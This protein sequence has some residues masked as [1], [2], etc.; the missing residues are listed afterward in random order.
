[1]ILQ[2]IS[3][4]QFTASKSGQKSSAGNIHPHEAEQKM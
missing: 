2:I 1:M 3:K 4:N